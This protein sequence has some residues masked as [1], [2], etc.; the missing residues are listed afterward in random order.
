MISSRT[1]T[2]AERAVISFKK[3]S[4]RPK[5]EQS[6]FRARTKM[7]KNTKDS[8]LSSKSMTSP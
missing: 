4:R 6:C 8:G 1:K 7:V 3:N 5:E 2:K